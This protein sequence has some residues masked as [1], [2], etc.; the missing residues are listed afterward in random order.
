MPQQQQHHRQKLLLFR[1]SRMNKTTNHYDDSVRPNLIANEQ[2]RPLFS[3][4]ESLD[5][6]VRPPRRHQLRK[7]SLYQAMHEENSI[8]SDGSNITNTTTAT[9]D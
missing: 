6:P 1:Y 7:Q 3:R 4:A 8:D 9:G 2:L 5:S